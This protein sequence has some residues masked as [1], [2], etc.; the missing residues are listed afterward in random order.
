MCKCAHVATFC[1]GVTHFVTCCK[2]FQYVATFRIHFP[3]RAHQGESRHFC[4]D[5]V[6][7]DPVWKLSQSRVCTKPVCS[8]VCPLRHSGEVPLKFCWNYGEAL[9]RSRKPT[10]PVFYKPFL[11]VV[12]TLLAVCPSTP[13]PSEVVCPG[14]T[15][16]GLQA[17]K[18]LCYITLWYVIVHAML[19]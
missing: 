2:S 15:A 8:C 18:Q 1:H 19:S 4:D 5:L 11:H 16:A 10:N 17:P 6:C 7:H 14:T 12:Q 3:M 9:K 13:G